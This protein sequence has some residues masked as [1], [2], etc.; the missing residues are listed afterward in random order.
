MLDPLILAIDQGT[1]STKC[2]LVGR[3]GNAVA[4]GSAP[5]GEQHPAPGWVEQD[6]EELWQS[7]QQAVSACLKGWDKT[8]VVAVGL[9]TQ[10][11]SYLLWERVSGKAV[12]PLISWQDRRTVELCQDLRTSETEALALQ[13]SG[14]PLD[15]MF[16]AAKAKW[17]LDHFDLQRLRAR[18]GEL[19]LGTVDAW[20]LF[21]LTGQH[22]TEVGNASRTQLLNVHTVDWDD[23]L[24]ALF[25]VPR[26][27]LPEIVSS[28][29]SFPLILNLPDFPNGVA[30]HA[31]MGDSHSALFAHGAFKPGVVKAT[32][33]TGSSLMGLIA[34]A[35]SVN[36]GLCL[37][38]AWG[39]DGDVQHA[40]EGN[41]RSS[42]ATVRWVADLL[43]TTPDELAKLATTQ[44]ESPVSIVPAFGGLGAPWWDETAVGLISNLTLASNRGDLAYAA[45]DSI[46]QQVTDVLEAVGSPTELF[47]DGGASAN[48]QLMQL[49]ANLIGR[50]VLRSKN[51]ELSALGVAHL[52]GLGAGLWTW[53]DLAALPREWEAFDPRILEG[54]RTK[55]RRRWREAVARA[56]GMAVAAPPNPAV[57]F[58]DASR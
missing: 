5:L 35:T 20:L 14:L 34:E 56:R 51:A 10:R 45:I 43:G 41:I 22:L 44:A 16:S 37:T 36:K 4:R 12:A 38:V 11:E 49:Q 47:A 6:P 48:A 23:D 17:L 33:G 27:A 8:Q 26:A 57:G 1:S 39:L 58:G 55:V 25:D 13:K 30:L 21:K 52:A 18:A 28:N 46:A 9:S 7:V 53:E 54:E 3:D 31:V 24:L 40:A 32:Y 2:L 50:R 29:G 15:P 42:G 19:C